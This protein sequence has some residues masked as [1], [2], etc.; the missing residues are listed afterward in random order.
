MIILSSIP[1]QVGNY[2]QDTE[3]VIREYN[4]INPPAHCSRSLSWLYKFCPEVEL[5][6]LIL[7]HPV[8]YSNFLLPGA[9]YIS[10]YSNWA[11]MTVYPGSGNDGVMLYSIYAYNL[12]LFVKHVC[13]LHGLEPDYLPLMCEPDHNVF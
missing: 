11:K 4:H 7:S 1:V 10:L 3:V 12:F 6:M 2:S 5:R 8:A 13:P 9:Y